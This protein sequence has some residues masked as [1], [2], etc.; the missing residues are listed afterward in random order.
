MR[1]P[2]LNPLFAPITA[3]PGVGPRTAELFERLTGPKVVDLLWHLPVGVV[4]RRFAPTIGEAP[5]GTIATITA[6]VEAHEPPRT[7]RLPY[8]VRLRD[9]TGQLTL[10]F[11]H[12][13]ED[14]L[15]K[16][17]PVGSTRIVS[18][19]IE[20]Y[21][22]EAQMTHPDYIVAEA[23]RASLPLIE[24]IYGLTEGLTQKVV[25]KAVTGALGRAP[26]LP[27]WLD[28]NHR[29]REHWPSWAEALSAAHHPDPISNTD[30]VL[31]PRTP[32]RT[33]LAYDEL[34]ANQLALAL[35][36]AHMRRAKAGATVRPVKGNGQLRAQ[37]LAALPFALT[38]GQR[39]AVDEIVADMAAPRRMLRLLQGDV[40]SGKTVVAFL[41][42]L[43]AVEA[44]YQAA[45]MAP[46]EI[47]AR[48]HMATI[49]PLAN[50]IGV[51]VALLT[52]RDRGRPRDEMIADIASGEIP[53]AIGTHALIEDDVRFQDLAL[54][55]VDEQHRFGVEQRLALAGKGNAEATG[56]GKGADLLVMTA[57]PIPR[58]LMLT[59]YGDLDVSRLTEKP[60]GRKP[61]DTRTVPLTR[62][63]EVIE[64]LERAF[65]AAPK[66]REEPVRAF[67]VCPLVAPSEAVDLAAAEARAE[68]LEKVFPGQVALVHG[69]MKAAQKDA[70]MTAFAEGR[71][72]ILVATTVIEVGVDVPAASIMVI[73]HAERF[74]LAQLHQLRGRVGRGAAKSSCIL[75]YDQNLTETARA[76][77]KVL[78]ET[79]DGFRIAEEDLRLRG[80]GEILG[81]RQSGLP[82]FRLADISVHGDLLVAARDDATLILERDPGLTGERGGALRTLLYLFERD[83]AIAYAR[84]G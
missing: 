13:R 40:G 22:G 8:R 73:E 32:A 67:W 45:L 65:A 56:S 80:A 72:R 3:L 30:Q 29:E 81:T 84:A 31:D 43:N 57:T 51:R 9:A 26:D 25:A 1:P 50:A 68:A 20:R 46:T 5:E 63:P 77:L 52:G 69:R 62:M 71:A 70:A 33:R 76:R 37:A 58:T 18:G 7:K 39:T 61:I 35:F 55:V 75:L 60:A 24:P 28:A 66:P 21:R 36:R 49:E 79:D 16:M 47:L 64:G 6:K 4:D 44:G 83:S 59:A 23:Q 14:Y 54:A 2:V 10:V 53:I 17:L 74:G 34:L 42:M 48:Q 27:E 82:E 41:A 12:G 78:R 15:T 19:K 11:F 38:E